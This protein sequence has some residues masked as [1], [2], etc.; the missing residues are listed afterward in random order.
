[1]GRRGGGESG[2]QQDRRFDQFRCHGRVS[3]GQRSVAA[4]ITRTLRAG[5]EPFRLDGRAGATE[6]ALNQT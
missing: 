6:T 3:I 5:I 2:E 4:R 1:M